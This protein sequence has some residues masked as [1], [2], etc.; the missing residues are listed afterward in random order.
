MSNNEDVKKFLENLLTFFGLNVEVEVSQQG[1]SVV[2]S[3]PTSEMNGFLIGHNGET[4]NA[5][6]Y[7]VSFMAR[8]KD[9]E[10]PRYVVDIADYKKQRQERLAV[11]AKQWAAAVLASGTTMELSPMNAS[12]RRIV[13]QIVSETE[14][15][16]S[17][18]VDQGRSR[19]IVIQK[20]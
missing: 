4:L 8:S 18:S 9:K 13:H 10:A 20:D 14:G 17:E 16:S 19:H 1:E 11:Q 2:L 7:L 5:I 6:Q 15:V 3:V 12:D